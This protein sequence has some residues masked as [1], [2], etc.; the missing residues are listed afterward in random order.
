MIIGCADNRDGDLYAD[1]TIAGTYNLPFMS[2]GFWERAFAGEIFYCFP[3]GMPRYE[4]FYNSLGETSGRVNQNRR[5]Y[6]N[7][8]NLEKTVFEPGISVD[9][10][11]VTTIAI[12]LSIDILNRNN[13]TYKPKLINNLTQYTLICNTNDPEIGGEMAEIFSY[14]LQVT[15]SITVDYYNSNNKD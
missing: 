10:N 2:V 3:E 14:P 9:I 13:K 7:E 11:Y 4:D 1:N 5:F 6:T 15:T 8:E 12:K